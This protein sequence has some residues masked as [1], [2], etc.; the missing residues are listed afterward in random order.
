MNPVLMHR[1]TIFCIKATRENYTQINEKESA[2][3]MQEPSFKIEFILTA[4]F[5]PIKEWD[6]L[7]VLPHNKSVKC[8]QFMEECHWYK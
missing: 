1:A 3:D 4:L 8:R 7:V 2:A 5:F 6:P